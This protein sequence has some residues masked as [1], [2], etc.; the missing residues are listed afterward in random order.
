[1]AATSDR[2]VIAMQK[3]VLLPYDRYQ[4]LLSTKPQS[5]IAERPAEEESTERPA[6]LR[7]VEPRQKDDQELR[8]AEPSQRDKQEE[9]VLQFPKTL[10]NRARTLLRYL[11]KHFTWNDRGEIAIDGQVIPHSNIYDLVRV[12]LG[13]GKAFRP[14]GIEEFETIVTDVNVPLSLLGI[15]RREQKG[16]GERKRLPPPPG[17]PVKRK[18]SST[19]DVKNV[20]WLNYHEISGSIWLASITTPNTPDHME[21]SINCI[22]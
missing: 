3:I 12:Q 17:I 20:R 9:L 10:Q 22:V 14:I 11:D 5:E 21:G 15:S 2:T 8:S 1:M 19:T 4:R 7:S 13:H 6:Q 18:H 16:G